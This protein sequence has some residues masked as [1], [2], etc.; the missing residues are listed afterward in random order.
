M[1][2]LR[3]YL[4]G[5]ITAD[6]FASLE[7]EAIATHPANEFSWVRF[8]DNHDMERGLTLWN[9]DR[10][11]L[12]RATRI[13]MALPGVPAI[14]YGTEQALT[15]TQRESAGGLEVGRIPM[16]FDRSNPLYESVRAAIARRTAQP[17]DQSAPVW[18]R[19]NGTWIWGS[20]SGNLKADG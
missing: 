9:D 15:S 20:L 16:T 17:V 10:G 11:T 1:D 18:W 12:E 4:A 2:G 7:R 13:L 8:F 14:F 5:T 6:G 19:P 3:E